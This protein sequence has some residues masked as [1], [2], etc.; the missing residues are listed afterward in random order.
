MACVDKRLRTMLIKIKEIFFDQSIK[1]KSYKKTSQ[2][3]GFSKI[4]SI[5]NDN[6][7]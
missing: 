4:A 5:T 6:L 7:R 3:G 1:L 2:K